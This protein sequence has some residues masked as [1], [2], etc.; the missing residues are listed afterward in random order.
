MRPKFFIPVILAILAALAQELRL[1]EFWGLN[2]NLI[3][4][5]LGL[6]A[7]TMDNLTEFF[8]AVLAGV[9]FSKTAPF[10]EI[11]PLAIFIAASIFWISKKAS[12]WN[13]HIEFLIS[14]FVATTIFYVVVDRA[15]I[16]ERTELF[17]GE[18]AYNV[19][20]GAFAW[21]TLNYFNNEISR[22]SKF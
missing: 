3:I 5:T 7:F 6:L 17:F 20:I 18:L 15:F 13:I 19:S 1:F 9:I 12:P 11:A 8:A 2:P 10:W 21:L 22:R 16:L 4:I 14:L